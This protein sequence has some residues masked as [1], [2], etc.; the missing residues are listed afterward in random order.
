[1]SEEGQTLV[2]RFNGKELKT[3]TQ[4]KPGF[5]YLASYLSSLR[6]DLSSVRGKMLLVP[7][8]EAY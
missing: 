2:K 7:S 3:W 1:M 4:G 8:L 6:S 5:C